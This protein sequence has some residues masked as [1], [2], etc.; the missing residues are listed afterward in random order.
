MS[1]PQH[2]IGGCPPP[3]PDRRWLWA[4]GVTALY[5]VAVIWG[6]V[7]HEPWR[8]EVVPLSIARR[9]RSLAELVEPL[10]FE[11][12]PILWYLLLWG[13]YA[14]VGQT[15]V[16]KAASLACAIGAM[17]LFNRGG[18]PWWLKCLF[19]FSFYPLF[20][21]SVVCRGYSLEMLVLFAFCAAF[22]R[23]GEHPVALALLLAALANTEAFGTIMALA[24]AAMIMVDAAMAGPG[25]RAIVSDRRVLVAAV[26]FMAALVVASTVAF[27][28][29]GHRGTGVRQ[30]DVQAIAE[31]VGRAIADPAAHATRFGVLPMLSVWVWAYLAYLI[32]RP[33]LFCFAAIG[34]VGIEV[35]FNLAHGPGA[36]WHIGNVVLVLMATMILDASNSVAGYALPSVLERGRV[37]LGRVL[38]VGLIVLLANHVALGVNQLVGDVR[39]DYSSNRRLAELL[40]SDPG[41]ANAVLM[42]EP[43]MPLWSVSYYADNPIYLAREETYRA[44]GIFAP[45]RKVTYDLAAFLASARRVHDACHCPV[46]IAMGWGLGE[47]GVRRNFAGT[48]FEEQ[49]VVTAEAHDDFLAS[50]QFVASLRGPTMTDEQYDVFVLR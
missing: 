41:L 1:K 46:V 15:W 35:L 5:A 20:Q 45:P 36:P 49:F 44:W 22:P 24:A 4:L 34:F 10:K 26:V 33:P 19:T 39:H 43:D 23:R 38:S 8:D 12:H 47:V 11:G 40:K 29:A 16:L 17:L 32:R 9:A 42:G 3:E 37:W 21:Y 7:H 48:R 31:G 14:V 50:T 18:L 6:A 30:L 27:P 2:A 28:D 13:G 25:W